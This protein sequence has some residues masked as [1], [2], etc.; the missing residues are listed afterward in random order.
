MFDVTKN[1]NRTD[2]SGLVR[3]ISQMLT[4]RFKFVGRDVRGQRIWVVFTQEVLAIQ[5]VKRSH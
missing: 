5:T 4:V 1:K 2:N 3:S